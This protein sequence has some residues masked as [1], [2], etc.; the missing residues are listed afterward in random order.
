MKTVILGI[1]N[2]LQSDD[3]IGVHIVNRLKD[4]Y[5]FPDSVS[6]IDG[7]T[8][9]LDLLAFLEDNDRVLIVDAIDFH[10]EPGTIE[11]LTGDEIPKFLGSKLSVH[12]IGLSDMLFAAKLMGIS[13]SEVCLI[14]IQPRSV[15]TGLE[16]SREVKSRFEV[17]LNIVLQKL[18][19]WGI[20]PTPKGL[21]QPV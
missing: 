10:K 14:G 3:G 1:G 4:E 13:P 17:L 5:L 12:Q 16:L 7:G 20:K 6:I 11:T 21:Q 18:K 19:D 8:M 2:I 15:D 9:G